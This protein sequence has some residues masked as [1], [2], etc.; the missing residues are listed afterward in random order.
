MN[1]PSEPLVS[2][3]LPV[4]NAE[5]YLRATIDSLLAQTFQVFE[6]VAVDDGSTDR[7]LEILRS[8]A[9]VRLR[10][11][12]NRANIGVVA[13]LNRGIP[14]CRGRY[15]ARMDAD[16]LALPERLEM[17]VQHMEMHPECIL[18]G[19]GRGA[20]DENGQPLPSHENRPVTGSA[21]VHWKLLSGNIFIHP[22]VLMRREMVDATLY[23]ERYR[24]AEDYAAWLKLSRCGE[25]DMLP[26]RLVQVR[27][28][29]QSV[30]RQNNKAQL[31]AAMAAL[32]DHIEAVFGV[33]FDPRSLGLWCASADGASLDSPPDFLSLLRWMN[34]LRRTFRKRL[35]GHSLRS[36]FAH[37]LY[38][39]LLLLRKHRTRPDVAFAV[40]MAAI[41]A[42][43]PPSG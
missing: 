38:R 19:T 15:I 18:L 22:S 11:E 42:P 20:I 25:I 39:L 13:T 28:H 33:R 32:R 34:P 2:I 12:C 8:Y 29:S 10:I 37:Y 21:L 6:I 16:D 23:E 4:Y 43:F 1:Q 36:A 14:L 26:E 41:A 24:H 5:K 3:L 35:R 7:S 31:D 27:F 17:Q 30:S 40:I 9:D